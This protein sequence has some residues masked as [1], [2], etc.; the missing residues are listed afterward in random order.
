MPWAVLT[1]ACVVVA[2][3]R[4]S[5]P[6]YADSIAYR[7]LALGRYEEVMSSIAGRI[8]HPAFVRLVCRVSG[9]NIDDA[10]LLVA[11]IA[12]AVLVANVAWIMKQTTGA[13]ALVLPLLFTPVVTRYMFGLYYCQ[14]LFYAALLSG[15]F[16]ALMR[17]R[18]AVA[19]ILLLPLY[20]VR[21]ST[22]LLALVW[23]SIAWFESDWTTP[24]ACGVMTLI[25]LGMS[26]IFA[27]LGQSNI[28]KINELVFL[29]LKLPFDSLRNLMGI[30]LVPSEM[31]GR[32]GF[33]CVPIVT[34]LLPR[35]LRYGRT[36]QFGIC[37]LDLQL[38]LH[39]YALLLSLFGIGPTVLWSLWR[40]NALRAF[41]TGAPRWCKI[42]LTY[43]LLAF[44]LAPAVS[45]WLERDI[46]Y[47]WPAFWIATPFIFHKLF[48]ALPG[49]VAI[50]LVENA[51][52]CWIPYWLLNCSTGPRLL[53]ALGAALLM[54]G[55]VLWTLRRMPACCEGLLFSR[56]CS[57]D[58]P[59]N[60]THSAGVRHGL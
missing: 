55:L 26:R 50:L 44:L 29:A 57:C 20:L 27:N 18:T 4:T 6:L 56:D 15:L 42:A 58:D 10:F 48:P 31:E 12:L 51:F 16:I 32:P 34:V 25:G 14:D 3:W 36:T 43:G 38:P 49:M 22:V 39:T 35:F 54:Q 30:V 23:A 53:P 8:L 13:G 60:D 59:E 17:G 5:R 52:S 2:G 33:T 24:V 21:E 46:G 7:A 45:F 47:S 28:H 1:F 9:L 40:R 19:L 41:V 11:V 37:S